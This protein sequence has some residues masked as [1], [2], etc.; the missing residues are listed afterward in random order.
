MITGRVEAR[1]IMCLHVSCVLCE[2]RPMLRFCEQ[3]LRFLVAA[4]HTR[5]A[6]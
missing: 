3:L 6:R 2:Y 1:F 4:P 5:C